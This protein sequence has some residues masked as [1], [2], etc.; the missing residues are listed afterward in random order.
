[1]RVGTPESK[2]R[3]GQF[4]TTLA[5]G[6]KN[7]TAH[8]EF[9]HQDNRAEELLRPSRRARVLTEIIILAGR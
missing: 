3:C 4:E 5:A 1:V 6:K 7:R 9:T 8:Q 2:K